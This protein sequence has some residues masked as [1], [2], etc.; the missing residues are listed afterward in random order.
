MPFISTFA[1]RKKLDFFFSSVPKSARILEVGAG[2]GEV[3]R[4]LQ[5]RGYK[6]YK[7]LD[8]KAP[9]DIV[10]D[11][12]NWRALGLKPE[13]FDIIIAFEVV[14]HVPCYPQIFELLAPGGKMV[15]TSPAPR[16]DWACKILETLRLCQKR[17]SPHDHLV[18]FRTIPLFEPESLK[19]FFVLSQWGVFKKADR[20]GTRIFQV[21]GAVGSSWRSDVRLVQP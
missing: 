19:R 16:W 6:N 14:E 7:S 21:G 8:I 20:R 3:K 13:S 1:Q 10:G 5:A 18:D 12:L 17:T 2:S 4:G 15:L 9:A 11:I